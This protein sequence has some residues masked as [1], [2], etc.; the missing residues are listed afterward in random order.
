[1]ASDRAHQQGFA[2]RFAAL[3][4]AAGLTPDMLVRRMMRQGVE[5]KRTAIYDW[6]NG[7]HL[8]Q[9][10]RAFRA[11]VRACIDAAD[12]S[13]ADLGLA[14]RS[15]EHWESMLASA[16]AARDS[17]AHQTGHP[18]TRISG[19]VPQERGRNVP[20]DVPI[21][22]LGGLPKETATFTGR[23]TELGQLL[24]LLDPAGGEAAVLQ[25]FAVSGLGGIGKTEL[26]L[27]AAHH[28][29]RR[30]WFPGGALFVNLFGY[31]PVRRVDPGQALGG[32]MRELGI[33][34]DDIPPGTQ[35]RA[36]RYA[37]ALAAS[38]A[39]GRPILVI[40]DNASSAE[41]VEPLLPPSGAGKAMIT[42]RHVLAELGARLVGLGAL[43]VD[44]AVALLE[45]KVYQANG[46]A[47]T[48]IQEDPVTA[49][50]LAAVCGGLPLAL[51][52]IGA[53][54]AAHRSKPLR[55]M[56]ADLGARETRL[57]QMQYGNQAV[58]SA[59]E[60]SYQDLAAEQALLFRL[61]TVNTGP[62]ISTDAAAALT[63]Q[64]HRRTRH[65]L[66]ALS[67]ACMIEERP[68]DRWQMHD[69]V[70]LYAEILGYENKDTDHRLP[71]EKRLLNYYETSIEGAARLL[72]SWYDPDAGESFF[73]R[74]DALEWLRAEQ[75]NLTAAVR[76]SSKTHPAIT[77][78]IA[79]PLASY[80][81]DWRDLDESITVGENAL[82][83]AR[84]LRDVPTEATVLNILG[85]ALG[86]AGRATEALKAIM[87][88]VELRRDLAGTDPGRYEP[89]LVNGLANL[90]A[91]P[92]NPPE[93]RLAA[94][95]EAVDI[96]RRRVAGRDPADQRIELAG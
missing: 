56:A 11:V 61:L 88:S 78:R 42:S 13:K 73:S 41:Q 45:R 83:I 16:K 62:D 86:R 76:S 37:A 33:S 72:F 81:D 49:R 12:H 66:E 30:N 47:D 67:R 23:E 84:A 43:G 38:A 7:N 74:S 19:Q 94:A 71:A 63:Q 40:I 14:E 77:L 65:Q 34:R 21:L 79:V 46:P 1:M 48:R 27:Q 75:A 3:V 60:L 70:R 31:D 36:R 95:R 68:G 22:A 29:Q 39:Q 55:Q 90:A 57:D 17:K 32:L 85:I 51:Q 96:G 35:D 58:R 5:I 93:E 59:F 10:T 4:A 82:L 8:P 80:L 28:A 18:E 26:A 87:G 15:L 69:L 2:G 91:Q 52:L 9:D 24:A 50:D 44:E 54:L 92:G 53:N 25:V 89:W 64:D 6:M 20:A